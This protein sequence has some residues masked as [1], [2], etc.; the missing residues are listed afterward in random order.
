L[1]STQT[2]CIEDL[3]DPKVKAFINREF[4]RV[5]DLLVRMKNNQIEYYPEQDTNQISSLE[6][7]YNF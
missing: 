3:E 1:L 7:N 5:E 4:F 6:S 2:I